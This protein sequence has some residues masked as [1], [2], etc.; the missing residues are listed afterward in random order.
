[1]K[2]NER[3]LRKSNRGGIPLLEWTGWGV[4]N[5][6]KEQNYNMDRWKY[7][8][9]IIREDHVNPFALN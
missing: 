8:K 9:N 3:K 2:E 5:R 4:Q 7:M 1:M 6:P